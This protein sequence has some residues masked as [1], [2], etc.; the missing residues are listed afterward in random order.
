MYT[1]FSNIC[2]INDCQRSEV[3]ITDVF[4]TTQ[5][6]NFYR[7]VALERVSGFN[8]DNFCKIL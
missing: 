7:P 8:Y 3:L 4:A 5:K 1:E 6:L 2:M